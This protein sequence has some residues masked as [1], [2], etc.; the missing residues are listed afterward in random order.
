MQITRFTTPDG[1]GEVAALGSATV[2]RISGARAEHGAVEHGGIMKD[3]E[4]NR[5]TIDSHMIK[6]GAALVVA[7][8]L[9]TTAGTGLAGVAVTR[10]AQDWMRRRDVSPAA[11]A[12]AKMRQA[13]RGSAADAHAGQGHAHARPNGVSAGSS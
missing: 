1:I 5:F 9:M 3:S 4:I 13:R 11:A 8:L 12:A 6:V 2:T 7:G 10:A